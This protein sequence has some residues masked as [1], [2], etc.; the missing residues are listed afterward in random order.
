MLCTAFAVESFTTTLGFDAARVFKQG[1]IAKQGGITRQQ[2]HLRER[3]A[4]FSHHASGTP[5]LNDTLLSKTKPMLE[6]FPAKVVH[7]GSNFKPKDHATIEHAA[8]LSPSVIYVHWGKMTDLLFNAIR[9]TLSWGSNVVL[10][11]DFVVNLKDFPTTGGTFNVESSNCSGCENFERPYRSFIRTQG[12]FAGYNVEGELL[13]ELRY[14]VLLNYMENAAIDEAVYLDSDVALLVPPDILFNRK[15]YDGCDAIITY[16]Q[17]SGRKIPIHAEKL[18]AYWAGTSF[19]TRSVLREY[20]QFASKMWSD[21]VG[22]DLILT[23]M[24]TLPTYNDMTTWCL[25]TVFSGRGHSPP[26]SLKAKLTGFIAGAHR[27]ICN[28]QPY[29]WSPDGGVLHGASG[30]IRLSMVRREGQVFHLAG[31]AYEDHIKPTYGPE[32]AAVFSGRS[33]RLFSLHLKTF[34]DPAVF[35][36]LVSEGTSD[37]D[38]KQNYIAQLNSSQRRV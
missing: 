15:V 22:Q 13:N 37:P 21:A 38:D 17:V 3:K 26:I 33:F 20:V 11:C 34:G 24:R 2:M 1:G 16:G 6:A 36:F 10:L 14:R 5:S 8:R 19:V 35:E 27:R 28:S 9:I 32:P 29:S 31:T 12:E 7:D 23:K 18:D 25:F 30:E 4:V